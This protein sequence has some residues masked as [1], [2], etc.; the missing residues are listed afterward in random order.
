MN[1]Y[2]YTSPKTSEDFLK[3]AWF[4]A[5]RAEWRAFGLSRRN[6]FSAALWLCESPLKQPQAKTSARECACFR[7]RHVL[8]AREWQRVLVHIHLLPS[9][10][11]CKR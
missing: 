10:T 6:S 4:G 9:R 11:N 3:L 8:A 2:V 1:S 7:T 5:R